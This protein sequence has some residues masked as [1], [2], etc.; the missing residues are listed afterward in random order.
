MPPSTPASS[1]TLWPI[2]KRLT[3]SRTSL[4]AV[5]EEH[6]ADEEEQMVVAGDHVLGAEVHQRPDRNALQGLQEACVAAGHA[7]RGGGVRPQQ[8][9]RERHAPD[10]AERHRAILG[11][12]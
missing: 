6:D 4:Q 5:Q 10:A 2:V 11:C 1:V 12:F 7:V 8:E 3:Y 9:D